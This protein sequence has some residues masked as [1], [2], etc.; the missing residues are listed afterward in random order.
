MPIALVDSA[1]AP[2]GSLP[3][4]PIAGTFSKALGALSQNYPTAMERA[5]MQLEASQNQ[6]LQQKLA[7]PGNLADVFS[8]ALTPRTNADGTTV[9]TNDTMRENLPNLIR[10]SISDH[11]P[12]LGALALLLSANM[13]GA[14]QEVTSTPAGKMSNLDMSMIG[15]GHPSGAT[16][17]GMKLEHS[18]GTPEM[19]NREYQIN[20][21][22]QDQN[23]TRQQASAI[24]DHVIE[25]GLDPVTR[26]P[27]IMNKLNLM[28]GSGAGTQYGNGSVPAPPVPA[29]QVGPGT[30]GGEVPLTGAS[31]TPAP[32]APGATDTSFPTATAK[33]INIDFDK[34][35]GGP[36]AIGKAGSMVDAVLGQDN[37]GGATHEISQGNL[38]K[39]Q[40]LSIVGQTPGM[41]NNSTAM[42]LTLNQL[43]DTGPVTDLEDVG[44]Q[45]LV[46]PGDAASQYTA[47]M[48]QVIQIRKT[49]ASLINDTT[50]PPE[51]RIAAQNRIRDADNFIKTFG[52][53][54]LKAQYGLATGA[55]P[56]TPTPQTN[57]EQLKSATTVP[58]KAPTKAEFANMK[59]G[60]IFP[61]ATRKGV[62]WQKQADGS[63]KRVQ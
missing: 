22:M 33:D 1:T 10:G 58:T 23:A 24:V 44:K 30:P 43:P 18:L 38:F 55:V 13:K 49:D 8:A 41:R 40:Y 36:S 47:A 6:E 12:N 35:Y 4:S 52:S 9:S 45:A 34:A 42:G 2:A 26:Q 60:T 21:I 3:A 48:N 59:P 57:Q 63:S 14:Q 37:G 62:L 50:K 54:A 61:D 5:R 25:G 39:R 27:Y 28:N 31:D 20:Q 17:G 32:A 29:A 19:R 16:P 7:E 53:E 51:E 46:K 56:V 15:A 11:V